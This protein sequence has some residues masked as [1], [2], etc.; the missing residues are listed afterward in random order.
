MVR[1]NGGAYPVGSTVNVIEQ[2]LLDYVHLDLDRKWLFKEYPKHDVEVADFFIGKYPVTNSEYLEFLAKS[3][4]NRIPTS[5]ILGRFPTEKRNH[6]VFNVLPEDAI[7]YIDWLNLE[8]GRQFRLP[9]EYEWE[10]AATG[11]DGRQ[12]PWGDHFNPAYCNTVEGNVLGSTPVGMYEGMAPCAYGLCDMAGNVE[13]YVADDYRP[14]PGGE[15]IKD[16]LN[17]DADYYRIARGGS[18]GRFGDLARCQRRHG[19]FPES[20]RAIFPMGFRLAEN[21]S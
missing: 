5:W 18:F 21:V 2:V 16:H 7:A 14:Y 1:I 3:G 10:I 15:A 12:Y 11:G 6:P 8:T 19:L 13:E 9:T 17:H 4:Y 20:V